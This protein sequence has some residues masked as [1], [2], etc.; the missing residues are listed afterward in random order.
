MLYYRVIAERDRGEGASPN[1]SLARVAMVQAERV[2]AEACLEL[3]GAHALEYGALGDH[4]L[5][6]SLAAGIAAGTYE[7]QL[8]LI[9]RLHLRLPK[10]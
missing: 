1:P 6:K 5:R 4:Q 10:G 7:V 9:S 2:T 8:N 3:M